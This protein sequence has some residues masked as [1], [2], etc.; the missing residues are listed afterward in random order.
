MPTS[1]YSALLSAA[2][3]LP[4]ADRLK[5]IDDLAATVPDDQPPSLSDEWLAEI[6]RRSAEID[7]GVETDDG[8]AVLRELFERVGLNREA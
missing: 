7:A 4:V 8:E 3:R 2:A 6:E 5:L 1:D